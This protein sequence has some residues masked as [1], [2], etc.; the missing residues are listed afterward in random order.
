MS[1]SNYTPNHRNDQWGW[2]GTANTEQTVA[3]GTP[4]VDQ[5]ERRVAELEAALIGLQKR[6]GCELHKPLR[7]P[8][9][10]DCQALARIEEAL[11]GGTPTLDRL[12]AEKGRA[13]AIRKAV[14]PPCKCGKEKS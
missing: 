14:P 2:E 12:M 1:E 10:G 11:A 8:L 5:L 7:S 3:G 4:I 9:C 13:V 6:L